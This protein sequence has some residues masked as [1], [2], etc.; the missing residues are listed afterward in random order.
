MKFC[1]NCDNE[2]CANSAVTHFANICDLIFD[3][4]QT[5]L[6]ML[7]ECYINMGFLLNG[8]YPEKLRKPRKIPAKLPQRLPELETPFIFL[9]GFPVISITCKKTPWIFHYAESEID[10]ECLDN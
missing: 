5:E 6:M 9:E 1:P 7:D 8:E 4:N 10:V 3:S 2:V